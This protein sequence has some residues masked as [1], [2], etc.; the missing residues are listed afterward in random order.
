MNPLDASYRH[1]ESVARRR[2]RNFYY[3][4][5]ALPAPKRRAM[6]AL[7]AFMRECDDLSDGD[8]ASMEGLRLWRDV[9]A[10]ALKRAVMQLGGLSLRPIM[11]K[12]LQM[13]DELHNRPVAASSLFANAMAGPLVRAGVPLDDLL[14][15]L[16]YLAGHELL[17]LGLSM[18]AGKAFMSM[19]MAALSGR[20]ATAR[21]PD[22]LLASAI[23][24]V[25]SSG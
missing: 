23:L 13:G 19:V 1:C 24:R 15:T 18:A 8:R 14:S 2:A 21:S 25:Q 17:F 9:W 10:P 6:C 7:Y 20:Y 12:A 4:F 16:A 11:A 3:S 5:L 22:R